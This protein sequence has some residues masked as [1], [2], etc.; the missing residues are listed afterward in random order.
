MSCSKLRLRYPIPP[1]SLRFHKVLHVEQREPAPMLNLERLRRSQHAASHFALG[2]WVLERIGQDSGE[3]GGPA[4]CIPFLDDDS[5][6]TNF[7]KRT[8]R[9]SEGEANS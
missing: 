8:N 2:D 7:L 5:L 1:I 4:A 6:L 3:S 9:T